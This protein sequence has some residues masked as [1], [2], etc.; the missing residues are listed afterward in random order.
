[1][2]YTPAEVAKVAC[3]GP[4]RLYEL[5]NSG[6]LATF[7]LGRRRLVSARALNGLIERL[8]REA[9]PKDAA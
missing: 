7:K 3:I 5:I 2:V 9:M 6:D 8:E 4:T 1:L